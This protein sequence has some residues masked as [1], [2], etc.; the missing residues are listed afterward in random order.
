MRTGRYNQLV[1][2]S[3]CRQ[4]SELKVASL[5]R[6]RTALRPQHD[7]AIEHRERKR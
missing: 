4:H 7:F 6:A 3:G 1:L 5:K 2:L